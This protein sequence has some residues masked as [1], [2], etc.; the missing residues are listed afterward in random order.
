MYNFGCLKYYLLTYG[1]EP[2]MKI[3]GDGDCGE[4]SGTKIGRETEILG[5]NLPQCHFCPSQNPT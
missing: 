4:I 1:T 2:F 5:G 3:I